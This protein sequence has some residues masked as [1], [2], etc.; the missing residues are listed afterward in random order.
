MN[1]YHNC[2][3]QIINDKYSKIQSPSERSLSEKFWKYINL[4]EHS[5]LGKSIENSSSKNI[6]ANKKCIQ[7][8][9]YCSPNTKQDKAKNYYH[10][11]NL[12]ISFDDSKQSYNLCILTL[13]KKKEFNKFNK[14][15]SPKSGSK[16]VDIMEMSRIYEKILSEKS[17]GNPNLLFKEKER[18]ILDELKKIHKKIDNQ[19]MYKKITMIQ[20]SPKSLND[21]VKRLYIPKDT[22]SSPV[23][24]KYFEKRKS[25]KLFKQNLI[26]NN[27]P[28]I[29]SHDK[30]CEFN[31]SPT[32]PRAE[33]SSLSPRSPE[34]S[35]SIDDGI[36]KEKKN[37]GQKHLQNSGYQNKQ[38]G[39]KNKSKNYDNDN[40]NIVMPAKNENQ[41]PNTYSFH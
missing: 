11:K 8:K 19:S 31:C 2:S 32:S 4:Y 15:S 27:Q 5:F 14:N 24:S 3:S 30:Y 36:S 9:G 18:I 7:S 39:E 16:I 38:T 37:A 28:P 13:G 35:D 1:N 41:N 26:I 40:N 12:K 29:N 23:K 33:S 21:I 10:N 20:N 6:F 22:Q 17:E 34:S 25:Q